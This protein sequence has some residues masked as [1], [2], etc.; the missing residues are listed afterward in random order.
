MQRKTMQPGR[1][2]STDG[3]KSTEV[4][5]LLL[6]GQMGSCQMEKERDQLPLRCEV[7]AESVYHAE[8]RFHMF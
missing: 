5:E 4:S 6:M 3:E 7:Q 1:R 8:T 2:I